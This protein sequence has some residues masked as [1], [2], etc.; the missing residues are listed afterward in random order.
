MSRYLEAF[1][2]FFGE[3]V[4]KYE[5]QSPDFL[6]VIEFFDTKIWDLLSVFLSVS[7]TSITPD[8]FIAAAVSEYGNE[9]KAGWELILIP[10]I[11][12][13]N[14]G[15]FVPRST[16]LPPP[17]PPTIIPP[18]VGASTSLFSS[19]SSL[20]GHDT[21]AKFTNSLFK[22]IDLDLI[23]AGVSSAALGKPVVVVNYIPV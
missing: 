13:L 4:S 8:P 17:L 21:A 11:N 2:D 20:L 9:S 16:A 10:Y 19:L 6:G 5:S 14:S 18:I 1:R 23:A 15:F 12:D 7:I 22:A 3:D